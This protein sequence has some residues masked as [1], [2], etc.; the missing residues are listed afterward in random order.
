MLTYGQT[1]TLDGLTELNP[2]HDPALTA[3]N[4]VSA[5]IATIAQRTAF[6]DA[7]WNMDIPS[8]GNRYF[9]GLLYLISLL[10]LG[11]QMHVL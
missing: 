6:V 9:A 4:G 7:V 5:A 11:G 3:A 10:V 2:N 8:M 1:Y